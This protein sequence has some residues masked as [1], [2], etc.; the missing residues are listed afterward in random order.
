MVPT[1]NYTVVHA[2]GRLTFIEDRAWLRALVERLT[3]RYEA[4]RPSP[5]AVSDTPTDFLEALLGGFVG[6]ELTIT[7]L[8]GKWKLG[9]NRP[10]VDRQGILRGLDAEQSSDAS[11]LAAIT[12]N[13]LGDEPSS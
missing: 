3:T 12:R 2:Y 9:Q 13:V 6:F 1:W 4:G 5:W 7:R 8:V 10:D 11:A